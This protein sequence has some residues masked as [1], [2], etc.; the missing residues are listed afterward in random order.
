MLMTVCFSGMFSW[1]ACSVFKGT[2]HNK[3]I[4]GTSPKNSVF[5]VFFSTKFF[6]TEKL[7]IISGGALDKTGILRQI[8]GFTTV[9]HDTFYPYNE[10]RLL[11]LHSFP[12]CIEKL[13]YRDKVL[14]LP[15]HC[16]FPMSS[17]YW[18]CLSTRRSGI[19]GASIQIKRGC[20]PNAGASS[21]PIN[22]S[23]PHIPEFPSRP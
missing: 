14:V 15:G 16:L 6:F 23:F 9:P 2:G 21:E 19:D 1:K 18:H 22:A 12:Y 20:S 8:K 4:Q 13:P 17:V 5:R 11:F 3:F 7:P 10:Q